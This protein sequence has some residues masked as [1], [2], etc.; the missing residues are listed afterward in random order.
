MK[1][2]PKDEKMYKRNLF[3][4]HTNK[5]IDKAPDLVKGVR[6]TK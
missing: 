5:I 6:S 2:L 3:S 1:V 4:F